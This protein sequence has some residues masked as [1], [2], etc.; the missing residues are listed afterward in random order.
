MFSFFKK[1]SNRKRLF[2]KT[3]IHSHVVPGVDDG[4][5]N[6][7]KSVKLVSDL[8]RWGIE[9]IITTPHVTQDKYENTPEIIEKAFGELRRGLQE[10]EIDV[11]IS[12]A[13]ENR[14][15]EL[16]MDNVENNRLMKLPND[17]LLI[18]NSFVQEPWGMDQTLFKLRLGGN[19]LILA[20]P[21]RYS[22]Y[23]DKK[24]RYD[25]LHTAGILFQVNVLSLAG[26]Y[27]YEVKK[28]AEHLIDQGY[29]DFLGTDLH[30]T[31]HVRA[32]DSY[33]GSRSYRRH[34][35]RLEGLILNDQAFL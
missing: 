6:V 35:D 1:S 3:D 31:K 12:Y 22:Y 21:E 14:I 9:R 16:L 25:Q 18:E 8:K 20:H 29:V 27:G 15:D 34:R 24:E 13:S 11:D 5:P 30:R 7:E 10:A 33:L 26:A 4:S 32:I 2:Y 17:Y 28:M 23:F 19:K